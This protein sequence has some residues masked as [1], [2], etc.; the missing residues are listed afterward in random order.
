MDA[1]E[2]R[3]EVPGLTRGLRILGE[4]SHDEPKLGAPELAARLGVPKTTV[5]RLLQTLEREGFVERVDDSR[6][7][8]LG[9][10]VLRLGF[11]YLSSLSLVELGRPLLERL[12]DQTG[13]AANLVVRDGRSI[14]YV[15]KSTA[16]SPFASSVNIGTR[17]PAHATVLGRLLLTPL[18]PAELRKLFPEKRLEKM[19]AQTPETVDALSALVAADR[20]RGYAVS[21]GFFEPGISTIAAPVRDE[22]AHVV[23][24]LGLTISA[25]SI[26]R[27]L[28]QAQLIERTLETASALSKNL[29]YRGE[30]YADA[31]RR[32]RETENSRRKR[33]ATE[34][35]A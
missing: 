16:L 19:T 28:D 20:E 31:L 17:L 11:E 3:Y 23:A 30:A 35:A 7:Y 5:F 4:F 1:D 25:P 2:K 13:F 14:I 34:T 22:A 6:F 15:A 32:L 9:V 26:E 29:N 24:A 8:R 18:A 27:S 33:K 10:A 12:R 21:E